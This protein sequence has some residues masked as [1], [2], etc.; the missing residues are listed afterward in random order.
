[1]RN[2]L[3]RRWISSLVTSKRLYFNNAVRRSMTTDEAAD[4]KVEESEEYEPYDNSETV[5]VIKEIIEGRVR[6]YVKEDGGDIRY[7]GFNKETGILR[8]KMLGSCADCPSQDDTLK[9]G[10]EKMMMFYLPEV[11]RVEAVI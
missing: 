2:Y 6:P 5:Q 11:K 1:M 9:E 4:K 7:M 3:L 8:L 10:I